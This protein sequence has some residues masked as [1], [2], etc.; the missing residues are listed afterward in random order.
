LLLPSG[1][2]T[3]VTYA[4]GFREICENTK[5]ESKRKT[6]SVIK[7]KLIEPKKKFKNQLFKKSNDLVLKTHQN[8]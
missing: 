2:R 6:Q 5:A 4:R 8:I 1:F 7:S 3:A